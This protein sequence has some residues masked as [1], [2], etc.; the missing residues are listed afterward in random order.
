VKQMSVGPFSG[1]E[2]EKIVLLRGSQ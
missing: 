2:I 1:P